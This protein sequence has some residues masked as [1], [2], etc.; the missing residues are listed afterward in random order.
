MRN[1]SQNYANDTHQSSFHPLLLSDSFLR[2]SLP[3]IPLSITFSED[4]AG[5]QH[6]ER[7]TAPRI[8][9]DEPERSKQ[10]LELL[11]VRLRTDVC[12]VR[13]SRAANTSQPSE[14]ELRGWNFLSGDGKVEGSR[15]HDPPASWMFSSQEYQMPV[16]K[17][18]KRKRSS[19]VS[20]L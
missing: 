3:F 8:K 18:R 2:L 10:N 5:S 9:Q 14:T 19:P 16:W 20:Q 6:P 11:V 1:N 4:G 15:S 13:A 17:R 7:T 12:C